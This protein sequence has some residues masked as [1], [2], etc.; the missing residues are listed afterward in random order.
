MNAMGTRAT[1]DRD[2]G[3]CNWYE[4]AP[5]SGK[6]PALIVLP[7]QWGLAPPI[8]QVC[9][10]LAAEQ[11]VAIAPDFGQAQPGQG[12][13]EIG[14]T[15][16][17]TLRYLMMDGR[18]FGKRVGVIGFSK[19]GPLALDAAARFPEIGGCVV[20]YGV[21]SKGLLDRSRVKCPVMGFFADDDGQ[22]PSEAGEAGG[23]P[24]G[25]HGIEA[26]LHGLPG[27][28][29]AFLDGAKAEVCRRPTAQ[30]AWEKMISFLR[31]SLRADAGG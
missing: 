12:S 19:D 22:G 21:H 17:G 23:P 27:V 28:E 14:N 8:M 18:V 9:D 4:A 29:R 2:G 16:R 7:G 11:F 3:Q 1:F 26:D 15:I 24:L 10:L 25:A 13:D 6:G 30:R 5:D 31:N 20:F